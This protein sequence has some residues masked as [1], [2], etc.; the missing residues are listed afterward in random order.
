MTEKSKL[1]KIKKNLLALGIVCDTYKKLEK[2]LGVATVYIYVDSFVHV[3]SNIG[4]GIDFTSSIGSM[5]VTHSIDAS[6]ATIDMAKA[7]CVDTI[8]NSMMHNML[9]NKLDND[10]VKRALDAYNFNSKIMDSLSWTFLED[11]VII[12]S[13]TVKAVLTAD[14]TAYAPID[15]NFDVDEVVILRGVCD[16]IRGG[17]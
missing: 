7:I 13:S 12:H 15:G 5:Y 17:V 6:N 3:R 8:T 4:S 9:E 2:R 14:T 16:K 11:E 10:N 1:A